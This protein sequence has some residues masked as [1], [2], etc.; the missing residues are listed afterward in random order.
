MIK[1]KRCSSRLLSLSPG[2]TFFSGGHGGGEADCAAAAWDPPRCACVEP[3]AVVACLQEL[4]EISEGGDAA[5][6]ADEEEVEEEFDLSDIMGE[7]VEEGAVTNEQRLREADEAVRREAE[8]A[9]KDAAAAAAQAKSAA[10]SKKGK[11]SK[12]GK[13]NKKAA[14]EEL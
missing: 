1:R 7:E 6:A 9:A 5:V 8:A 13:S 3:D 2:T 12:K 11:K 14:R 4:P 10:A